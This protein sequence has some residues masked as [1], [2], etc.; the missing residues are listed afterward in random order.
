MRLKPNRRL[1]LSFVS[2]AAVVALSNVG[3]LAQQSYVIRVGMP[4]PASAPTSISALEF[5]R[6]AEAESKGRLQV[7]VYPAAQLVTLAGMMSQVRSGSLQMSGLAIDYLTSYFPDMGIF[8]LL[9]LFESPES[10]YRALDGRLGSDI[11]RQ[12]LA[13]TGVRILGF[14]D[15]GVKNVFNKVRP[16]HT[17][18]DFKGLRIRV[19]PN[20]IAIDS[21]KALGVVP[22]NV[23][24]SEE[25]TAIQQGVIDGG[26]VPNTNVVARKYYEVASFISETQHNFTI[27]PI[28][29]NDAFYTG[30]PADLQKIVNEAGVKMQGVCRKLSREGDRS[31]HDELA[32]MRATQRPVYEQAKGLGPQ[33]GIWIQTL[34]AAK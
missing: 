19:I 2:S 16:I 6:L 1:M 13:H 4:E 17:L 12:V 29:I 14:G 33:A 22:S 5:K 21:F 3:V 28:F 32:K 26:E 34:L 8:G 9:F 15:F 23:D 31:A 7:Q 18:A 25:Y 27:M 10:G 24:A 11:K 20:P 30:L